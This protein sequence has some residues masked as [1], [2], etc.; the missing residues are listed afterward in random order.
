MAVA[1]LALLPLGYIAWYTVDLGWAGVQELVFRP[2]VG[3]LVWNTARLVLGTVLCCA[4]L[5]A[6]IGAAAGSAVGGWL[7]IAGA[8]LLA[9]GAGLHIHR[10]RRDRTGC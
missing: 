7:G 6:V 1:A 8:V 3:E 10:R 4:V 9:A 2:R 5:P